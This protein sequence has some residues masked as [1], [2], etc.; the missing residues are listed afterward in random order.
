MATILGLASLDVALLLLEKKKIHEEIQSLT[1][2]ILM[3]SRLGMVLF[4][5]TGVD[6][7]LGEED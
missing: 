5:N 3:R 2:Q 6:Q 4:S 1:Q 7:L